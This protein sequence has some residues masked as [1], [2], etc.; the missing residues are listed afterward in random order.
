M[1]LVKNIA[2]FTGILEIIAEAAFAVMCDKIYIATLLSIPGSI[3]AAFLGLIE[4]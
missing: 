3:A 4:E 1:A 2:D